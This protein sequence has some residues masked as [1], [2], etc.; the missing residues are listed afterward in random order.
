LA[1]TGVKRSRAQ[2]STACSPPDVVGP[3]IHKFERWQFEDGAVTQQRDKGV[4]V[5]AR[6]GVR[7]RRQGVRDG[8]PE[9]WLGAESR[10]TSAR[11]ARARRRA[12]LTAS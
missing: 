1:L 6:E 7:C 2:A 12:L 4:D 9:G 10:S 11:A 5:V 3:R 8:R